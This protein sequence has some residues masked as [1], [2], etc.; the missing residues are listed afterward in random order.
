MGGHMPGIMV[1]LLGAIVLAVL[2]LVMRPDPGEPYHPPPP[3]GETVT[4]TPPVPDSAD[5]P[6][7]G[8]TTP[9]AKSAEPLIPLVR[10]AGHQRVDG[11]AVLR[12]REGDRVRLR[13]IAD[14]PVELHLHG[15]DRVLRLAADTEQLLEFDA[16]RT[17]RFEFELHGHHGGGHAGLGVIEVYP[18]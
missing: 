6:A 9:V 11:P 7:T 17:G 12:V 10:I 8:E 13:F 16:N 14:A 1:G 5:P 2:F 3:V 4:A 15:Y 18:R